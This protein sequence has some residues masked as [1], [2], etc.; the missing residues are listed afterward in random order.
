MYWAL[1]TI[2]KGQEVEASE[3]RDST[4]QK[5]KYETHFEKSRV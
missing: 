3:K 1:T 2:Y 5:M 4:S